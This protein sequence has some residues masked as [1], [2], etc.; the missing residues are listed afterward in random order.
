VRCRL[1]LLH[2]EFEVISGVIDPALASICR[3]GLDAWSNKFDET[4]KEHF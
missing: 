1:R 4:G 2:T 3:S